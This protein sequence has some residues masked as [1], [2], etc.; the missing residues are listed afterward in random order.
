M[1]IGFI[2]LGKMG[3]RMTQR[4]MKHGHTCV[5]FDQD[6]Q[7][8]QQVCK[9]GA[10]AAGSLDELVQQLQGPRVVWVM[11]PAGKI[12]QETIELLA[13][14]MQPEDVIIDGGNSFYKDDLKRQDFL[15]KFGI[16]L[17]DVGTSGGVWG[18]ENG[19]C[20]MIGGVRQVYEQCEPLFAA[21][22]PGANDAAYKAVAQGEGSPDDQAAQQGY[23]WCGPC[24]SGHFVKMVH[25]GIE[26]GLMQAYAEGFELLQAREEIGQQVGNIAQ[27]WRR[28]S[29]VR[30]W[31][32][33]LCAA[34]LHEDV[35]LSAYQGHVADSGEGRWTVEAALEQRVPAN[36]LS[37]ALYT[38]FRSRQEISFAEKM[39]SAMRAGFGGHKETA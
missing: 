28:G 33:D 5:V 7:A 22:A 23:L 38:R 2:G 8:V 25:N 18:L 3:G 16:H 32:L 31:L 14:R 21:L 11:L 26:Y 15:K 1:K 12:T 19:Y 30:S 37:C 39:L 35:Q 10:Q 9:Q 20:L 6:A 34:A 27:V 24:G 13:K 17:L 4:L 36:V 29:V